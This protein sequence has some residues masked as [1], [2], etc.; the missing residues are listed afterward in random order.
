MA[1]KMKGV[2]KGLKVISQIFVV[3]EHQMEIGHP[4][5]VKHVA[6][7]GWDSPTGSAA[8]PSW[9]NDMKGSPDFSSLSSIGPSARTSWA[10]QDF[11]EPRDISPFGIFAENTGQE[12]TPYP[13]IPNPPR[14]S[15]KKSMTGSP[16][17]SARSSRSSRSRSKSSFSSTTANTVGANDRQAEIQTV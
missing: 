3:K 14:K 7:I 6:H 4:T 5:D 17:A 10:S 13:D 12:A 16:R 15:R 1:Y 2:F 9:M 8:S 11:E